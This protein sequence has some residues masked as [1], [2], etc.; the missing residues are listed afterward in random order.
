MGVIVFCAVRMQISRVRL[1]FGNRFFAAEIS[2]AIAFRI[3][4]TAPE[5]PALTAHEQHILFTLGTV[6][7]TI[8]ERDAWHGD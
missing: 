8:N 1:F 5:E 4:E 7:L 2:S 3:I 6:Q